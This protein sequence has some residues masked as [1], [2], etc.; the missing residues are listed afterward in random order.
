MLRV[1]LRQDLPRFAYLE[2]MTNR[3]DGFEVALARELAAALLGSAD[4]L[5]LV[6]VTDTQR[7]PY[8]R[9]GSVDIVVAQLTRGTSAEIA[10]SSPY[11]V[12]GIGVLVPRER[13]GA[14]LQELT[15]SPVC[16]VKRSAALDALRTAA[17]SADTVLVDAPTECLLALGA[18]R[19]GAMAGDLPSLV[20]L[21]LEDPSTAIL[22]TL[23]REQPLVV[24]IPLGQSDLLDAVNLALAALRQNGR[25]TALHRQYF[26]GLLPAAQPPT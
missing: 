11:F 24:G 10:T 22:P 12:S 18:G 15:A 13:S 19:A 7:V 3:W 2:P 6:R 1:G 17:P 20:R 4:Q 23:L 25:W 21:A 5:E 9:D 8:L 14:S 26:E 16:A